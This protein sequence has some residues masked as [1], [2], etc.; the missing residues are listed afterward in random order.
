LK[1]DLYKNFADQS[2][3]DS[4][5]LLKKSITLLDNADSEKE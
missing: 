3:L 5:E 2:S 1:D 4:P